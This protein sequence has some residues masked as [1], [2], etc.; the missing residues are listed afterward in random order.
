MTPLETDRLRLLPLTLAD[1]PAIQAAFPVWEV[2]RWIAATVPWPY[3]DDGAAFFVSQ[4]ALPAMADGTAWHWSIRRRSEPERLIGVVSLT[5]KEDDNRGFW[6]D[7]VWQGQG[8]ATEASAAATDY[9]F[10]TLGKSVLRVPKA[11][12]NP[13]SRRVSE[14]QGMRVVGTLDLSLVS[15]TQPAELWEID[16]ESWR[17]IRSTPG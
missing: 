17:A 14:K 7:P 10:E 1:A 8:F 13:A 15:G 16:R 9:W 3:P 12:A 11:V 6:I 4:I 2:V 5:D